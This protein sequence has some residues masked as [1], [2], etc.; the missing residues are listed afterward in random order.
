M[1][2]LRLR[3]SLSWGNIA[4]SRNGV[5]YLTQEIHRTRTIEEDHAHEIVQLTRGQHAPE[6]LVHDHDPSGAATL[7]DISPSWFLASLIT[8]E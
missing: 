8:S 4:Q 3:S 6:F 7:S 5:A 2:G 1:R